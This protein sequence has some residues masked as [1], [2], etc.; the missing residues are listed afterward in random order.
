MIDGCCQHTNTASKLH[1]VAGK[2][3]ATSSGGD[4]A[5]ECR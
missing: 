3:M 5:R 2:A 4:A 1:T